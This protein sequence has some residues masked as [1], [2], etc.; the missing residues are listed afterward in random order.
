[1]F[2]KDFILLNLENVYRNNKDKVDNLVLISFDSDNLNYP[3]CCDV[4]HI[5]FYGRADTSIPSN[6][7]LSKQ[8][9]VAHT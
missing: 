8:A 5:P 7:Y 4:T 1:M 9:Y 6:N 3:H 2:I